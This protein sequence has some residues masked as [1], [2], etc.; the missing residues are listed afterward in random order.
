MN[1]RKELVMAIFKFQKE[2]TEKERVMQ[3]INQVECE[4]QEKIFQLGKMYYEEYKY[5]NNI[6]NNYANVIDSIIKL[7]ENRKGFYR[8]KLHLEGLMMCENCGSS[9]AFGSTYCNVCGKRADVKETIDT[10]TNKARVCKNCGNAL[11]DTAMFC[12]NCGQK[13]GM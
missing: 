9:I 7:E 3:N 4:I 5:E 6:P 10:M 11:E 12:E 13:V 1:V 8:N 2:L